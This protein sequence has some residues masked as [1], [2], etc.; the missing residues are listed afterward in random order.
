MLRTRLFLKTLRCDRYLQPRRVTAPRIDTRLTLLGIDWSD[1]A[2]CC[3]CKIGMPSP[4]LRHYLAA[5]APMYSAQATTEA[6]V[7]MWFHSVQFFR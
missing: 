4:F 3:G 1:G 2:E 7:R 5:M 6:M